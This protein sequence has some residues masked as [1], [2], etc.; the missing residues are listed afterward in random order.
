MYLTL[1]AL[2]LAA[3][4]AK[5]Q[6]SNVDLTADAN[7]A[8]TSTKNAKAKHFGM[9]L[10]KGLPAVIQLGAGVY[11][12]GLATK[13]LFDRDRETEKKLYAAVCMAIFVPA[14]FYT[15][16][17]LGKSSTDSFKQ[18]FSKTKKNTEATQK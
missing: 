13:D 3:P 1:A 11:I 15:G 6:E 14:L 5:A 7:I 9:G 12:V 10:L 2:L 4:Y 18:A 17:R 16:W 8:Q